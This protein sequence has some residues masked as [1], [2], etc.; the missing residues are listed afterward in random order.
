MRPKGRFE[1]GRK[2]WNVGCKIEK[3]KVP[4][5]RS[6]LRRGFF[7]PTVTGKE[8]SIGRSG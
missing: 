6:N 5:G 8:T 1:W 7:N 4:W 2:F 3:E